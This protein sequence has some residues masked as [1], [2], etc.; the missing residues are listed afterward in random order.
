MNAPESSRMDKASRRRQLVKV[1]VAQLKLGMYVAELDR[2]WLDTP[3][4]L[5]G[6]Y[7]RT[8]ADLLTLRRVCE[9]VFVDPRV[10]DRATPN[11]AV[12]WRVP[13]GMQARLAAGGHRTDTTPGRSSYR[14]SVGMREEFATATRELETVTTMMARIFEQLRQGKGLDVDAMAQAVQPIIGSVLRNKDAMAALVRIKRKDEY[15]YT[16]SIST[17]I[18]ATVF[19]RHL[20]FDRQDL[21]V[22][23]LSCALLDIGKASLPRPLLVKAAQLT[24]AEMRLVRKHVAES[25]RRLQQPGRGAVSQRCLGDQFRGQLKIQ[26]IRPH[27]LMVAHRHRPVA[28]GR[29]C[30][31]PG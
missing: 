10:V 20:G 2:P 16:H 11:Q 17:S 14:D 1:P 26:F 5:Q 9:H 18:W 13:T 28:I 3:F 19:G 4:T 29:R 23:A 30:R 25:V 15:T 7:L 22:L 8:R 31:R 21:Q 6:F 24:T 12:P 27:R